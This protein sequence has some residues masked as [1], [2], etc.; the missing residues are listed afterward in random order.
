[1]LTL[2]VGVSAMV[3]VS[4]AGA[5]LTSDEVAEEMVRV[6]LRADEAA[7]QWMQAQV[8]AEQLAEDLVAAQAQLD[9][10]EAQ[11]AQLEDDLATIAVRR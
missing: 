3:N 7:D 1:M 10:T 4:S 5:A 6:Q 11:Y 8:R 9:L 2:V